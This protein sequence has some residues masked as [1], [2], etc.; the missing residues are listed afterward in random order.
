MEVLQHCGQHVTR[1]FLRVVRVLLDHGANVNTFN[2]T[3]TGNTAL[4][5]AAQNGH[6]AICTELI[7]YGAHIKLSLRSNHSPLMAAVVHARAPIVALL[8]NVGAERAH[9]DASDF[10]LL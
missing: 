5:I 9:A 3:D 8:R 10:L 7:R 2:K 1:G 6:E 4:F